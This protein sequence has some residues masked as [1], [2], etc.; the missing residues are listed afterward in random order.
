V[1]TLNDEILQMNQRGTTVAQIKTAFKL[2]RQAGFKIHAHWMPNLYG[3]TVESDKADYLKL[4]EPELCPDEIK[5][6]PTSIIKGTELNELYKAGKYRPYT[7]DELKDLL[8]YCF[9][10]TP[11]YVRLTRIIRDIPA[12]EIQ[13]GN[14]K[15][16]LRQIVEL[17]MLKQGS[18]C[19]CIRCREIRN[20]SFDPEKISLE[21]LSYQTS[22]G[23]EEFL[24]FRTP[25][26]KLLGFLRL[27]LP[28]KDT[29]PA[30]KAASHTHFL[31][32]LQDAAIIREI[33]VY[34]QMEKIG[35]NTANKAQHLG[36]GKKL[37]AEAE[38]L[39]PEAGFQKLAVISAI[40]TREYYRKQGFTL[41]GLY[42]L[43]E[44]P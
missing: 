40:G 33:H 19:E 22:A 36:L 41:S 23:R 38:K 21:R 25:D 14:K 2:L 17:E 3:A 12:Q 24:S 42:Q 7:L 31:A 5:I 43:K 4:W 9:L 30:K 6:Y 10:H 15:S 20:S 29:T 35:D 8:Q 44:L 16:N 28:G 13:A 26:D 11:R 39:T 37:I 32:E 34:G 27:L 18:H 1:Q